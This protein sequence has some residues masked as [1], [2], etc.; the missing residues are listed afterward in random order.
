VT[1]KRPIL[2]GMNNP[3]SPHPRHALFP[4]PDGCTGHRIWMMLAERTGATRAQYL[5]AFDRRNLLSTREWSQSD[6]QAAAHEFLL[7]T[8]L[9]TGRTVVLLGDAPRRA[10]GMRKLLIEP[11]KMDGVT[12]RQIPHPSGRNLFYNDMTCRALIAMLLEE[13]YDKHR[14]E[15]EDD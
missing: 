5:A 6:A 2:L 4:H 15:E 9:M 1:D 8:S 12:W 11:Q 3:L 7:Q 13:L 10:F 14:K